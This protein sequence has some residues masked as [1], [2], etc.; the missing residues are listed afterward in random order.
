MCFQLCSVILY[1]SIR[2]SVHFSLSKNDIYMLVGSIS[3]W[4]LLLTF[5]YSIYKI[6]IF[7]LNVVDFHKSRNMWRQNFYKGNWAVFGLPWTKM[8][9]ST[10]WSFHVFKSDMKLKI[11]NSRVE[12]GVVDHISNVGTL[13]AE[14]GV[15]IWVQGHPS[16]THLNICMYLSICTY[17][18]TLHIMHTYMHTNINM[19]NICIWKL[20]P[21][22]DI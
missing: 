13:K 18:Y 2:L 3:N 7:L 5:M 22:L 19:H 10:C 17:L 21:V 15:L 4:Y 8:D 1:S 16:K 14:A 12:P 11:K 20:W 6:I 9:V